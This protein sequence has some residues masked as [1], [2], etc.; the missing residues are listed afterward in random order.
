M[1]LQ[2]VIT[3]ASMTAMP[4]D[5]PRISGIYQIRNATNNKKYIGSSKDIHKRWWH[6][7]LDL[8]LRTHKNKHLLA[9]W[10][11]YGE[12]SFEF[13]IIEKCSASALLIREQYYI[14]ELKPE[15]NQKNAI[16]KSTKNDTQIR[17]D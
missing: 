15:Y 9:S 6:H 12:K 2:N 11:K 14:D 10:R 16:N 3:S 8:T 1:N 4:F 13:S 7:R 17:R 5:Y